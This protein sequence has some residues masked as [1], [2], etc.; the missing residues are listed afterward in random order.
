MKPNIGRAVQEKNHGLKKLGAA[1]IETQ[2]ADS[3][4]IKM[5]NMARS[6]KKENTY[7]LIIVCFVTIAE[8]A[9]I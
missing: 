6:I 9:S 2:N 3:L 1:L 4:I 5:P 8:Q 7:T